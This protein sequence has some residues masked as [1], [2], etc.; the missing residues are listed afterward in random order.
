MHEELE[1]KRAR[2][3]RAHQGTNERDNRSSTNDSHSNLTEHITCAHFFAG[4]RLSN[5]NSASASAFRSGR[6]GCSDIAA[7]MR[8]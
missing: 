6:F 1:I 5:E 2:P 4:Q 3:S 8:P 7:Q